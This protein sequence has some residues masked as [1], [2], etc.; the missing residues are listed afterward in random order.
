MRA[1]VGPVKRGSCTRAACMH[2][3]IYSAIMSNAPAKEYNHIRSPFAALSLVSFS[4]G[5]FKYL[6]EFLLEFF[7][8]KAVVT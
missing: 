1:N 6:G 7:F 5:L 4:S 8:F 2:L 3:I